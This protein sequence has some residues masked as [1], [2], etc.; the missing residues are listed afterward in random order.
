MR[1]H[2]VCTVEVTYRYF[3]VAQTHQKVYVEYLTFPV[4]LMSAT[5]ILA[6]DTLMY[7]VACTK[8][9]EITFNRIQ[10]N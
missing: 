3:I 1:K 8:Y 9:C 4:C 5:S 7:I 10:D 2:N 6:I